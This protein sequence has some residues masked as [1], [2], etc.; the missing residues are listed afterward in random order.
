MLSATHR[1]R[2]RFLFGVFF[3]ATWC[4][5]APAVTDPFPD[6]PGLQPAVAFWTSVFARWGQG[7]VVLHD[8]RHLG[9]VY[10]VVV[11]PGP[12]GESQT[13]EQRAYVKARY[14]RLKGELIALETAL[15]RG[16]VLSVRQ[17]ELRRQIQ[18]HAG[19]HGWRDA[20]VRL[21]TQRGTRQRFMRGLT[22]GARYEPAFRAAFHAAG[23]PQDLALLPHVESSFNLRARS[24][25]GAVGVWQ[26]MP[27]AARRFM[28][29]NRAIDERHDP[30]A[31]AKGAARYLKAAYQRLDNWA[32][33]V[34][35]YNHGIEGMA[36]A[37][38]QFGHDFDAIVRRYQ[39]RYFGFASRNF[40]AEFLAVR[41]IHAD[42][43]RY[44]P[45]GIEKDSPWDLDSLVLSRP[46]HA[47]DL[48][49]R[50]KTSLDTLV[51]LNPAWTAATRRGALAI[52]S[53]VTVWLP[54]GALL[55][56]P[57]DIGYLGLERLPEH[58]PAMAA[59]TPA[60]PRYHRVKRGET[61]SGI[62]H[63]Y[64]MGLSSLRR[65][66]GLSPRRSTIQAGQRLCIAGD[67]RASAKTE[68][69]AARQHVVRRGDSLMRIARHH[70]VT[71]S[72]L[73]A[74]NDLSRHTVIKPGQ[75]LRI[76]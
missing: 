60:A 9:L 23:L 44:F 28:T 61:L 3:L 72:A 4:A 35:S 15:R 40:Y 8:D 1:H 71:L 53:G 51:T 34:T 37:R 54:E 42:L 41:A 52:P 30:I 48:A 38:A 66:N 20:A 75:R 47:A 68:T 55:G 5:A 21:R 16:A 49:S 22:L 50:Y 7:E 76:P 62:A 27:S 18:I 36:R 45:E 2:K 39:S 11:L 59:E 24:S 26:F 14:E 10:Q 65:L 12:V 33:A 57:K 69:A 64:G 73:L 67:A 46:T 19:S 13:A 56:R 63:R 74:A 32:L 6:P 58:G 29:L 31:S 25:V 43:A 70:G 17:Q